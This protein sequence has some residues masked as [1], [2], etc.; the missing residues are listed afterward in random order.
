MVLKLLSHLGLIQGE[1]QAGLAGL[2]GLGKGCE[3]RR[4]ALT[5]AGGPSSFQ[6]KQEENTQHTTVLRKAV[7][8]HAPSS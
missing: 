8:C 4:V 2:A 5:G 6:G 1:Q 7:A 3:S